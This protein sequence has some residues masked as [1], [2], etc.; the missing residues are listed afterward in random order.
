M[1][2]RRTRVVP[3]NDGGWMTDT[4]RQ[5][6]QQVPHLRR[7]ARALTGDRDAADDLVQDCLARA[8]SR[9]HLWRRGSNIRAWLFTIMHNLWV[10]DV[11]RRA[12]R[13]VAVD[14][15]DVAGRLADP[16]RQEQ[17]LALRD[18]ERGLAALGEDQRA[19]LL[20]VGLEGMSYTEVARV[21]GVPIGTVMSRLS[22]GREALRRFM[23]GQ[24]SSVL[25]RVK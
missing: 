9:L 25:R 5:I 20:L 22:R 4:E 17:G 16:P 24:Q 13:P 19:V 3:R 11:R 2:K 18:L 14:F 8:L 15:E 7:Y 1:E 10:N 23:D 12:S 6:E 21:V